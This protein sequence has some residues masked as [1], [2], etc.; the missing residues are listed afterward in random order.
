MSQDPYSEVLFEEARYELRNYKEGGPPRTLLRVLSYFT[1]DGSVGGYEIETTIF[2]DTGNVVSPFGFTPDE[3]DNTLTTQPLLY[4]HGPLRIVCR[5][6]GLHLS[7]LGPG[8]GS[9][10]RFFDVCAIA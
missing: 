2:R 9:G 8:S 10:R 3:L 5:H 1:K 7:V 6:V 4:D